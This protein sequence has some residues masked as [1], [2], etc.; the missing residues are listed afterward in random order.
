M[1]NNGKTEKIINEYD[2]SKPSNYYNEKYR[3]LSEEPSF[4]V[5]RYKK[6]QLSGL[7]FVCLKNCFSGEYFGHGSIDGATDEN[8]LISL[9][10]T[11]IITNENNE[12][13]Y[14]IIKPSNKKI[15]LNRTLEHIL[16]NFELDENT[17]KIKH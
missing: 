11:K 9:F 4:M 16:I 8:I 15:L 13:E 1:S 7:H 14:E 17:G 6:E 5:L 10:E 2:Y 3:Y 12:K